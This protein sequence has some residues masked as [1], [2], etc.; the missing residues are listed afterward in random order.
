[1]I[2][3]EKQKE[4]SKKEARKQEETKASNRFIEQ[5]TIEYKKMMSSQPRERIK[6]KRKKRM[7]GG[8][9]EK[10]RLRRRC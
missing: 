7:A 2:N 4:R 10:Q 6:N 3:V 9:M 8:K 5:S 1:M